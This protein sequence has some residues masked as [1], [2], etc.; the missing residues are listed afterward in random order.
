MEKSINDKL[1]SDLSSLDEADILRTVDCLLE[2][3]HTKF[4][5]S[6]DSQ[7]KDEFL[8]HFML[9]K[10]KFALLEKKFLGK[11]IDPG[12][13]TPFQ[14]NQLAVALLMAKS[15]NFNDSKL[16]IN[17][18]F[19]HYFWIKCKCNKQCV[20]KVPFTLALEIYS[21][22]QKLDEEKVLRIGSILQ[23]LKTKDEVVEEN[24]RDRYAYLISNVHVCKQ[25]FGFIYC[26]TKMQ[27]KTMQTKIKNGKPLGLS[28]KNNNFLSQEK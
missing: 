4:E 10:S 25:F 7:R 5:N 8:S 27:L 2:N 23:N 3:L 16:K 17:S 28:K 18:E 15:Q 1:L 24:S 14:G 20:T 21:E 19:A 12:K 13:Y 22:Y 26:V 6:P 9:I 11:S